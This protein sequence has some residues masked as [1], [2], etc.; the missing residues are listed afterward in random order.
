[1]ISIMDWWKTVEGLSSLICYLL[2]SL[3]SLINWGLC[4]RR[5][6]ISLVLGLLEQLWSQPS[7][8]ETL[9]PSELDPKPN[10]DKSGQTLSGFGERLGK[11]ML[12]ESGGQNVLRLPSANRQL[13]LLPSVLAAQPGCQAG[14]VRSIPCTS[15]LSALSDSRSQDADF[16]A[17]TTFCVSRCLLS[18]AAF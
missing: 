7:S 10:R 5:S 2:L 4:C 3:A 12:C 9:T 13:D 14:D 6:F 18:G 8:V 1:M 11:I 17:Y 15:H 16:T